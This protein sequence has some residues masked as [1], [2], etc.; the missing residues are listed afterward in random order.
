MADIYSG[1]HYANFRIKIVVWETDLNYTN[2]TSVVHADMYFDAS[3]CSSGTWCECLF[4]DG[5]LNINGGRVANFSKANAQYYAGNTYYLGGGSATV[6]HDSFGRKTVNVAGGI[7]SGWS[8]LGYFEAS[9][10]VG[11]STLSVA[12]SGLTTQLVE[13]GSDFAVL[14]G[15][16]SA[17]GRPSS[18]SARYMELAVLGTS[19]YGAPYRYVHSANG[20]TSMS[21]VMIT[22]ESTTATSNPLTITPNTQYW[23]GTYATNTN[24][25]KSAVAGSFVTLP[26]TFTSA[27]VA[28][29][30]D[31]VRVAWARGSEGS[32]SAVT[33]EYSTNNRSTWHTFTTNPFTFTA[34]ESGNKTIYLRARNESGSVEVSRNYTVELS[35]VYVGNSLNK[36]KTIKKL[37][38]GVNN[39]SKKVKRM[40]VGGDDGMA[41][42]VIG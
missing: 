21:D 31:Q 25:S 40:Y 38:V 11:L 12:P 16:I 6:S 17:Y 18:E 41:K 20:A 28:V 10:D 15:S 1:L 33:L 19:T 22:N 13:I 3:Q 7:T 24:Q 32:A 27:T 8:T 39:Y 42:K 36:A 23:F 4:R 9:G 34:T 2:N 29:D 26:A 14:S 30:G 5:W 35:H 37:Y